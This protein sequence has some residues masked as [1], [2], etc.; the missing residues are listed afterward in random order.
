MKL[1]RRDLPCARGAVS[2]EG[3]SRRAVGGTAEGSRCD[4]SWPPCQ[5]Q[6]WLQALLGGRGLGRGV[7]PHCTSSLEGLS[8]PTSFQDVT[9]C[10]VWHSSSRVR[11][12]FSS[13]TSCAVCMLFDMGCWSFSSL[14]PFLQ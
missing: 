11:C 9:P 7:S 8:L 2:S 10:N 6:L 14:Q 1:L 13:M 12:W 4:P 5:V 3:Q